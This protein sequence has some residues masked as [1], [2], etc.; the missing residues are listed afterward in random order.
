MQMHLV[1]AAT[2][3]SGSASFAMRS[4]TDLVL[5]V[6]PSTG[7]S[8]QFQVRGTVTDDEPAPGASTLDQGLP[9]TVTDQGAILQWSSRRFVAVTVEWSGLTGGTLDV[10][11]RVF[12]A[13][14][15][16]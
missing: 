12:N 13:T 16:S 8:C 3:G 2:D 10:Y 11:A 4:Y 7:Q 14:R 15:R 6:R 5:S 9:I 1:Q